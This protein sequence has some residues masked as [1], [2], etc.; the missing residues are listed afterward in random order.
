MKKINSNPTQTNIN[1]KF[2]TLNKIKRVKDVPPTYE[3]LKSIVE[4]LLRE[5]RD[6]P[7][8]SDPSTR[9]TVY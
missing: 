4:S 1:I 8:L 5:E 9:T 6:V 7:L 3:A 2:Q